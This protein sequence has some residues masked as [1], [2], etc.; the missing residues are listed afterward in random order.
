MKNG[1]PPLS[2]LF[3]ITTEC[4][5][6]SKDNRNY[7]GVSGKEYVSLNGTQHLSSSQ[8]SQL[9]DDTNALI[10]T[11]IEAKPP[12]HRTH[13]LQTTAS[14]PLLLL[15]YQDTIESAKRVSYA[16]ESEIICF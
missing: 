10:D 7:L 14:A 15:P 1:P 12:F 11:Q 5:S 4:S 16:F 8:L 13:S 6:S 2:S 9:P 3:S